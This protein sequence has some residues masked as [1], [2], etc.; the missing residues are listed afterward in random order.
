[1]FGDRLKEIRKSKGL[2]Q[3]DLAEKLNVTQQTISHFESG[4][5]IPK[6]ETMR[7]IAAALKIPASEL[8]RE[9]IPDA[10]GPDHSGFLFE[11][12]VEKRLPPGYHLQ[13]DDE[14]AMLW[15]VYPDGSYSR[16]ISFTEIEEIVNKATD[17]LMYELEKLR[18]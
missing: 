17:Y 3:K 13:Y 2:S 15:L 7:R 6:I 1:M 18:R 12:E 9:Y 16:D 4:D 5:K 11:W 10:S 14:D 8:F